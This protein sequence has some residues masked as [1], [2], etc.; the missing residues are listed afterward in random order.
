M[1]FWR[2]AGIRVSGVVLLAVTT[3]ACAAAT[4]AVSADPDEA[5]AE[6][7]GDDALDFDS[8]DVSVPAGDV[9]IALT[10]AG[11]V[12]HDVVVATGTGEVRVATCRGEGDRAAGVVSLEPG[13]YP[14][15]CSVSGHRRA[16]MEGELT[17]T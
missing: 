5:G 1:P 2:S 17:V 4:Q 13:T 8:V 9:V 15:W 3:T 14:F 6:L 11:R 7:I 12:P 16:G 10:C